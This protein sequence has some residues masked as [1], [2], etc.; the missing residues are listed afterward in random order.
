MTTL[1]LQAAVVVSPRPDFALVT[2]LAV[3]G[4][5]RH[6]AGATLGLAIAATFYAVLTTSG[7]GL[8]LA[9]VG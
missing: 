3:S 9:R 4:A 8:L 1:A 2:W 6:A 5:R 7:L